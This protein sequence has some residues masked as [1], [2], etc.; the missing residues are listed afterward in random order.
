MIK[1]LPKKPHITTMTVDNTSAD[2]KRVMNVTTTETTEAMIEEMTGTE[3]IEKGTESATTTKN[4]KRAVA[5][6]NQ[7]IDCVEVSWLNLI[8]FLLLIIKFNG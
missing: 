8:A 4:T 7:A 5:D 2:L 3:I 6:T 1:G